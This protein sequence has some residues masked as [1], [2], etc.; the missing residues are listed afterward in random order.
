MRIPGTKVVFALATLV[1]CRSGITQASPVA[2]PSTLEQAV[3]T[4][5]RQSPDHHLA[6]LDSEA[7]AANE[8][9]AKSA[10]LPTLSFT[11]LVIRGNDPVFVFGARL[12]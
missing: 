7:A 4:A 11:E 3:A 6:A 12:S 2:D 8:R 1:S 9:L 10:L 5:L